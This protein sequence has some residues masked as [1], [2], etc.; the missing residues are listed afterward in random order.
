[1][2]WTLVS[3]YTGVDSSQTSTNDASKVVGLLDWVATNA[4]GRG[5]TVNSY[6]GDVDNKAYT[7]NKTITCLDGSNFEIKHA[8]N[9]QQNSG[10]ENVSFRHYNQNN[11]NTNT[12][13]KV[14]AAGM[15]S[16][17]SYLNDSLDL[18]GDWQFWASDIDAES[19]MIIQK[20]D[21]FYHQRWFEGTAGS[22][23]KCDISSATNS[24]ANAI[25][26]IPLGEYT[27]GKRSSSSY[28]AY[29]WTDNSMGHGAGDPYVIHGASQIVSSYDPLFKMFQEDIST[30]FNPDHTSYSVENYTST[31][32]NTLKIGADYYIRWGNP[33]GYC[34]MLLKTGTVN[35]GF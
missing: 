9:A 28:V 12:V 19:F 25:S 7:Y 31:Q 10:S 1:M 20:R 8:F 2:T 21:G 30:F 23:E 17:S 13:A 5:Y 6:V 34:C 32:I 14:S 3:S 35:P 16:D 22:R 26:V 4:G 29:V 18:T 24:P 27:F 15:N 11:T 33:S